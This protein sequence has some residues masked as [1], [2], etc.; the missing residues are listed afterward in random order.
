MTQ[1][2]PAARPSMKTTMPLTA[3]WVTECRAKYGPVHVDQCLRASLAGQRNAFYAVE[4]GH[5]VGTPF[6]W[7]ERAAFI[8]SMSVLTG[9]KFIAAIADPAGGCAMVG[10]PAHGGASA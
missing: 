7:S 9:G 6:D 1:S 8:V 4:A 10:E 5:V 2:R 3:Q